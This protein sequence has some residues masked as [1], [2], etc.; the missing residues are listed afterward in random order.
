MKKLNLVL[1]KLKLWFADFWKLQQKY[2]LLSL[3]T[4]GFVVN[5][6][7]IV[8]AKNEL[9]IIENVNLTRKYELIKQ[10]NENL[11]D[12]VVYNYL[13]FE[14][15]PI[16]TWQKK[17]IRQNGKLRF[18][19]NYFNNAYEKRLGHYFNYDR[20]N[21]IGKNNFE[22]G[23]PK[24]IAYQYWLNDSLVY[25]TGRPIRKI[26]NA[27]DKNRKALY[28]DIFKY[29]VIRKK[30]TFIVGKILKYYE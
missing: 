24:D 9:L 26:E 29:R 19:G 28:F 15:S 20:N 11:K 7:N 16:E 8:K 22:L 21:L 17:A 4:V 30:D 6:S 2:Q 18:V 5:Q 13:E 1:N 14:D 3:I 10:E 27:L 25:V 12:N 23:Y